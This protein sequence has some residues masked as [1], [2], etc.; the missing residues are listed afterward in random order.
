LFDA[1]QQDAGGGRQQRRGVAA[2]VLPGVAQG[3]TSIIPSTAR[4]I[5]AASAGSG[6]QEIQVVGTSSATT[7]RLAEIT[8]ASGVLAPAV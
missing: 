6:N 5:V 2:V 3:A 1:E 7:I 8:L 4:M